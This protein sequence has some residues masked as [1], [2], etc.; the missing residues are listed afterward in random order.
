MPGKSSIAANKWCLLTSSLGYATAVHLARNNI[1]R[2]ILASRNLAKSQEA[3]KNIYA[4]VPSFRGTIDIKTVDLMSFKSVVAFCDEIKADPDQLDIV[5]ANAGIMT[6]KYKQTHDGW[7]SVLQVNA[8][9]TGL[10]SLL[11]L[12]KLIETG[13]LGVPEGGEAFKP[14]LTI[15]ASEGEYLRQALNGQGGQGGRY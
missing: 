14:H 8:L 5:V 3:A 11:L 10:M 13:K 4:A 1:K 15:V 7:E 2:I 9:S 12:P 6:T